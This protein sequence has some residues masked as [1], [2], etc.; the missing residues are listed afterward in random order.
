M[1]SKPRKKARGAYHHGDLEQALLEAA[2]ATIR[3]EGV[4]GLTLR[5]V[6]TQLGVSRTA[7]YRHF[8]DKAAL[9]ARVAL[10]G[11]RLFYQAL[12]GAIARAAETGGDPLEEMGRAYVRFALAN[13]A[14][15]QTM[16]GGYLLDWGKYPDL[17]TQ[18]QATFMLLV[19]SVRDA[20]RQ[21]RLG[22]GEPV[23]LAEIIWSLSHGISTL[24]AARQL[25]RTDAGVE[26]LMVMACRVFSAGLRP[27]ASARPGRS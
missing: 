11:F 14:H 13:Q 22:P 18:A 1:G 3:R 12:A 7:L 8:E 25:D 20:Q 26:D 5:G 4:Q 16:F 21:G 9:V 19:D 17:S 27:P 23:E 10:E 15:Y 2:L 24:G 6:G